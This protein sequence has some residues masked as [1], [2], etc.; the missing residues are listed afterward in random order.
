[1]LFG[2]KKYNY[3]TMLLLYFKLVPGACIIKIANNIIGSV[4]PTFNIIITAKFLNAAVAAVSDRSKLNAVVFPLA[5]IIAVSLFNYYIGILM[6]MLNTRAGNKIRK[7][8][9]PAIAEK[10][11]AVKFRYYENQ[12]SVDIMNRAVGGFEGNL[13][14]FFDQIF[15]IW[16]LIAQIGGFI[17]IL[18]MQLWWATIVFVA[19]YVPCIIVAYRFGKKRYDTDKEMTK[20]DRKKDYLGTVKK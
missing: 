11:I 20:I 2:K 19:T 1:M 4:I 8:V 12:E 18:G 16:S 13:Q 14:G 15:N 10:K 5:A 3:M 6:G 17:I 9:Q 7:I